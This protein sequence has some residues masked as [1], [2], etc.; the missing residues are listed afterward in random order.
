VTQP[1]HTPT[2]EYRAQT[3]SDTLVRVEGDR[4][5]V[6]LDGAPMWREVMHGLTLM[7]SCA[8]IAL[9]LFV[10][11]VVIW[12]APGSRGA[13]LASFAIAV[14][15]GVFSVRAGTGVWRVVRWGTVPWLCWLTSR[16]LARAGPRPAGSDDSE[17]IWV[18]VVAAAPGRLLFNGRRELLLRFVLADGS[19]RQIIWYKSRAELDQLAHDL[20][21]ALRLDAPDPAPENEVA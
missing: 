6:V 20:R 7:S 11:A 15:V 9:L 4:V 16:Q 3:A 21:A 18:D 1:Y 14:V 8:T 13:S 19:V 5:M 2:L 10:R 17:L 12:N